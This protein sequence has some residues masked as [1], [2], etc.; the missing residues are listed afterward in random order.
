M[1]TVEFLRD[2]KCCWKAGDTREVT[3]YFGDVLIEAGVAK[4]VDAPTK[5]KMVQDPM[6]NKGA[7]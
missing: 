5:N 3:D 4:R 2:Y 6:R 1:I 7:G